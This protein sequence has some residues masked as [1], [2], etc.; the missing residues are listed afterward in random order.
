MSETTD[1]PQGPLKQDQAVD[2]EDDLADTIEWLEKGVAEW[3]ASA[4]SSE[5]QARAAKATARVAI[6]HLRNVLNKARTHDDQ[7]RYDTAARDWLDSIGH[8]E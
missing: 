6:E 7:Q 1:G 2:S 8:E 5:K 4:I 3:R